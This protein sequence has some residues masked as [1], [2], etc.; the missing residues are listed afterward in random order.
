MDNLPLATRLKIDACALK[1]DDRYDDSSLLETFR[2]V[3]R[4]LH[5][6]PVVTKSTDNTSR[7]LDK[8]PF[9]FRDKIRGFQGMA[10]S[11]HWTPID[12]PLAAVLQWADSMRQNP[13]G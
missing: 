2:D 12:R 10:E 7:Q 3:Q 8:R 4:S 13:A 1:H 5:V 11:Q 6:V 9:I